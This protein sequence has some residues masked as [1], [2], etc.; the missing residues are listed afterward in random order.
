MSFYQNFKQ[1]WERLS[2][3]ISNFL[4]ESWP[5]NWSNLGKPKLIF[6]SLIKAPQI[7]RLVF[8][9]TV[10]GLIFS[11]GFFSVNVYL[12]ATKEFPQT[13]GTVEQAIVGSRIQRLNPVLAGSTE[14]EK[15]ITQLLYHPLYRLEYPDFLNSQTEQIKI[16]PILLENEPEWLEDPANPENVYYQLKFKL[17]EGLKWSDGSD[18]TI[19]DILYSFDRLKEDGG[20]LDFNS[21][22]Q[23]Y[24]LIKSEEN[25]YEFYL[26]P[27]NPN[28]QPNPEIKYIVNFSPISKK[29]YENKK[30]ADLQSSLKSYA[31]GVSS[32]YFKMNRQISDPDNSSAT[33]DNPIIEDFDKIRAVVLDR[34]EYQNTTDPVYV[35]KYIFRFAETVLEGNDTEIKSVERMFKNNQAD[36]FTRFLSPASQITSAQVKEEIG[37]TQQII[38]SNTYFQFFIN[39][40]SSSRNLRGFFVNKALRKYIMCS[41]MGI[42]LDSNLEQYFTTVPDENKLIPV[43]FNKAIN[44]N[45]ETAVP[46]ILAEKNTR[47]TQIYNL[48]QDE[49]TGVNRVTLFGSPFG[50]GQNRLTL[51]G[52]EEFQSLGQQIQAKLLEI[53][54]PSDASWLPAGQLEEAIK[55]KNYHFLFLPITYVNRNPYPIYGS[56]S[57][58]VNNL[59][60]NERL[61]GKLVEDQLKAYSANLEN[62][63]AKEALVKL[64]SEEYLNLN[65][66]RGQHEINYSNNI[67]E[68]EKG[69]PKILNF[70]EEI[71]FNTG[72][73]YLERRRSLSL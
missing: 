47:G 45:C 8:S 55:A 12:L 7:I 32:G 13:G 6:D 69:V 54:M 46:E 71:G 14:A 50:E 48:S 22:F 58:N 10:I 26:Q 30:N 18:L 28:V 5:I 23:S 67:F 15:K 35:Q 57:R 39:S 62:L 38:P 66:F 61:N 41:F 25:D 72:N 56:E 70:T 37:L 33:V 3:Q 73:W 43:Q 31:A 1:F 40:Q 63:E 29:F 60:R 36:I 21:L 17:R 68:I 27:A 19:E 4:A 42:Q 65:L 24:N 2:L 20:N 51:I 44:N 64:Y 59:I 53:G 11:V 49:R 52:L 34:N 9:V 16:I